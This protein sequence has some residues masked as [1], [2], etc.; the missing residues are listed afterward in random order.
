[1]SNVLSEE[2]QKQILAL[3]QL[4]WSLRRIQKR[5]GIRRETAAPYLKAAGIAIRPPGGWGKRAPAKPANGVTTDFGVELAVTG[6]Y[7]NQKGK[8]LD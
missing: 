1:M 4:G 8:A 6:G 2:E 7:R 5:T 3:G